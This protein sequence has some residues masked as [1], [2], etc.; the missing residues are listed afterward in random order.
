MKYNNYYDIVT[1][2]FL[3]YDKYDNDEDRLREFFKR[4]YDLNVN[5]EKWL[6]LPRNLMKIITYDHYYRILG[7]IGPF[8]IVKGFVKKVLFSERYLVNLLSP[9]FGENL[10][11]KVENEEVLFYTIYDFYKIFL[12]KEI[13]KYFK[14]VDIFTLHVFLPFKDFVREGYLSEDIIEL[15]GIPKYFP[16]DEYLNATE[17]AYEIARRYEERINYLLSKP[18][19]FPVFRYKRD[20]NNY[21]RALNNREKPSSDEYL[22]STQ[23]LGIIT[24][25]EDVLQESVTFFHKIISLMN[26]IAYYKELEKKGIFE[27]DKELKDELNIFE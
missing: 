26:F 3:F 15:F 1:K 13:F 24:N 10:N 12:P 4:Y 17:E 18:F 9:S 2:Y 14:I 5:V 21:F 23:F 6:E 22:K 8:D 20:V 16:F 19:Y 11:F 7:N 27:E 25:A